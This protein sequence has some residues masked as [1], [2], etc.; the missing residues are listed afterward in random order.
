M[1]ERKE[2]Q[3]GVKSIFPIGDYLRVQLKDERMIYVRREHFERL[4]NATREQLENYRLTGD[5]EGVHWP[6]V[7]EDISIRGFLRHAEDF[8]FEPKESAW[9]GK[10]KV[11]CNVCGCKVEISKT[12]GGSFLGYRVCSPKCVREARWRDTLH[13]MGKDY[14]P[15]PEPYVEKKTSG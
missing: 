11:F 4:K 10:P 12:C 15:D 9:Y 8:D 7:D 13:T 14:R 5:G 6:D 2:S 1:D 3:P